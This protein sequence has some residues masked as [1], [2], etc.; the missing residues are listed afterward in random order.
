MRGYTRKLLATGAIAVMAAGCQTTD[1]ATTEEIKGGITNTSSF[2][3]A[4]EALW[5]HRAKKYYRNGNYGLAERYYRQAIEAR[6]QNPE[7]WLGLAASYDRLKRFDL[8]ERAYKQL[9]EI[10]GP[11]PTVLNNFAYHKMLRGDFEGARSA[12]VRAAENDPDNPYIRNNMDLL[13]RW[14][15]QAGQQRS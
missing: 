6:H 5:L 8:A 14:E 10:T 1:S 15:A 9:I 4:P 3:S 7:A 2:G 11:T 12:L 13:E